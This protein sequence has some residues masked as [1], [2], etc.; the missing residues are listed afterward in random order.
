MSQLTR[1]YKAAAKTAHKREFD[2]AGEKLILPRLS[3]G[4][5]AQFEAVVRKENPKFNLALARNRAAMAMASSAETVMREL[6]EAGAPTQFKD[7]AEAEYWK[8]EFQLRVMSKF[9]GYSDALFDTFTRDHMAHAVMLSLQQEYGTELKVDDK[10]TV[11]VDRGFVD[12]VLGAAGGNALETVFLWVIGLVDIPEGQ[13][14]GDAAKTLDDL[15]DQLVGNP[16]ASE[17]PPATKTTSRR[18]SRSSAPPTDSDSM[19]S[20]T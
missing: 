20:G 12:T 6:R 10:T 16:K 14:E 18:S 2:I 1:V 9:G 17:K 7:K 3:L 5:Q 11:D 19:T 4:R 13:A 15:A 8:Q